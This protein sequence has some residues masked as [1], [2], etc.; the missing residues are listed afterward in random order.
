M[1]LLSLASI[2]V[3]FFFFFF[4]FCS[5]RNKLS[6]KISG[7]V[8]TII[9]HFKIAVLGHLISTS[10]YKMRLQQTDTFH[11]TELGGRQVGLGNV[12]C[13]KA[14][15]SFVPCSLGLCP[16]GSSRAAQLWHPVPSAVT[17]PAPLP[18]R[19]D[20]GSRHRVL[21]APGS[22]GASIGAAVEQPGRRAGGSRLE[23]QF[24]F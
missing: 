19:R 17:A 8:K 1:S 13:G 21:S 5:Y 4:L 3:T 24:A 9:I 16:P 22:P 23:V 7:N 11:N 15:L 12:L 14:A 6:E 2:L 10:C 20:G 18:K